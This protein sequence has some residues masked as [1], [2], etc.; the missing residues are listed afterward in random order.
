MALS[1]FDDLSIDITDLIGRYISDYH[2]QRLNF[3]EVNSELISLWENTVKPATFAGM[4]KETLKNYIEKQET[5][6]CSRYGMDNPIHPGR[7]FLPSGQMR[8]RNSL[9]YY[10][11]DYIVKRKGDFE[12]KISSV[13]KMY[14][15]G[16]ELTELRGTVSGI[17]R[18]WRLFRRAAPRGQRAMIQDNDDPIMKIL[19]DMNFTSH[20]IWELELGSNEKILKHKKRIYD[21]LLSLE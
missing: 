19:E 12:N 2:R 7:H 21:H 9:C 10:Q 8:K 4:K 1:I 16:H 3:R 14:A 11:I 20:E 17:E 5:D 6:Y 13:P 15:G 18:G